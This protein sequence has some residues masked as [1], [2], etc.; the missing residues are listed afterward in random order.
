MKED[1]LVPIY[2]Y[3]VH[4]AKTNDGIEEYLNTFNKDG[5]ILWYHFIRDPSEW[6]KNL[7]IPSSESN[8]EF[9]MIFRRVI[10]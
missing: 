4:S 5:W 9:V 3:K 2:E 6:A 7:S 8:S 10:L 1:T